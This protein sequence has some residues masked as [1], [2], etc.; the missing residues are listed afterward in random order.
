MTLLKQITQGRQKYVSKIGID[1]YNSDTW[2]FG[3]E[4]GGRK[5]IL[6]GYAVIDSKNFL[7]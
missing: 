4:Q 1:F 2:V 6:D 5:Q 7:L 3:H